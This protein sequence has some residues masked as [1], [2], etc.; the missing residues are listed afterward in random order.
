MK[1]RFRG[2]VLTAMLLSGTSMTFAQQAASVGDLPGFGEEAYFHEE[3]TYAPVSYVG[4]QPYQGQSAS[5][6][7]SFNPIGASQLQPTFGGAGAEL[8]TVSALQGTACDAPGYGFDFGSGAADCNDPCDDPC[9]ND[10][11]LFGLGKLGN[12]KLGKGKGRDLFKVFDKVDNCT[13]GSLEALFWFTPDR[14]MI[15]LVTTSNV[16][17]QPILPEGG[18]NNVTTVWG[19]GID[20]QA[21]F[22]GRGEVGRFFTKNVGFGGRLWYVF[23]DDDDFFISGDGSG[24]SIGRPFF[25]TNAGSVGENAFL[26]A[27]DTV[28]IGSVTGETKLEMWAAEAFSRVRLSC[29]NSCR[30]DFI[31]GYSHFELDDTL[32]I[33]S[34]QVTVGTG[35][36]RIFNDLFETENRFNGGQVGF[37]M[38]ITRGRWMAR[39]LTKVHL[40]NMNQRVRID[41]SNSDELAPTP[42]NFVDGGML[43]LGNQGV[44]ERNEWSFAPEANFKLAYRMHEHAL[45]SVGYTFVYWDNV[46]LTGDVVDRLIDSTEI[47]NAA[48]FPARP[49][50]AFDDSSLWTQ[51]LDVGLVVDF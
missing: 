39:S 18:A 21:V 49:A 29:N 27:E 12:W 32:S 46:S 6:S 44:Y 34:T 20:G 2:L 1:T 24:G 14:D 50:F 4:D 33:S 40:G 47:G 31:G 26:I 8:K 13:W 37:E 38:V 10:R 30:L 9:D 22:G 25:D 17:T 35:R 19:D 43:A 36:T 23:P 11:G 42:P 15:P 51:G 3:A 7:S 48:P 5:A 41:G 45:I 16:G 28:F